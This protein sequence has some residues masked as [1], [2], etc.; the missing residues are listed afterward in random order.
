MKAKEK[1][2]EY[3]KWRFW[4]FIGAF[5]SI[6]S[7]RLWRD[8]TMKRKILPRLDDEPPMIALEKLS[9]EGLQKRKSGYL[10][11]PKDIELVL[12]LT[13]KVTEFESK[14]T[15]KE[16]T[17]LKKKLGELLPE[18]KSSKTVEEYLKLFQKMDPNSINLK[19]ISH[20]VKVKINF[21]CRLQVFDMF[22][23]IAYC[24]GITPE[25]RRFVDSIGN[26]I[27]LSPGEIRSAAFDARKS[28][29]KGN[30]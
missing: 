11:S 9:S 15:P 5:T 16:T 24:E 18:N 20:L 19:N 6:F 2:K 27:G 7:F 17:I 10:S 25:K 30:V 21:N 8:L 12:Q 26:A 29:S 4:E 22:Y 1:S 13:R 3:R 14:T 23:F 28:S